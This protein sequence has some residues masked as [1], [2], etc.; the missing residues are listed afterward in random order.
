MLLKKPVPAFFRLS[1]IFLVLFAMFFITSALSLLS[2]FLLEGFSSGVSILVSGSATEKLLR[3]GIVIAPLGSLATVGVVVAL[4]RTRE[5]DLAGLGLRRVSGWKNVFGYS[6]A[7]TVAIMVVGVAFQ[8]LL[9]RF[10]LKPDFSD[11]AFVEGDLLFFLFAITV[12][13][14]VSAAFTEEVVFRGFVLNNFRS[15]IGEN[16]TSWHVANVGQAAIFA[17]MHF[18]QGWGGVIPIFFVGLMFGYVYIRSG[19][20]LWIPIIAHGMIDMIGFTQLYLGLV[21]T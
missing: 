5:L 2:Y 12:F 13:T 11:F 20:N 18:N 14:W 17:V 16:E 7:L 1:E 3:Y 21:K 10:G 8:H 6:L 4:L 15:I 19:R 9:A